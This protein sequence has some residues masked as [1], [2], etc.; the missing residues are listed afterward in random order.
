[1]LDEKRYTYEKK[2]IDRIKQEPSIPSILLLSYS[3]RMQKVQQKDRENVGRNDMG[4]KKHI[5]QILD[6]NQLDLIFG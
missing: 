1:M 3:V 4:S 6:S 2:N 5:I